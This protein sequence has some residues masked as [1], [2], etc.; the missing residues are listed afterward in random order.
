VGETIVGNLI[1]MAAIWLVAVAVYVILTRRQP[2]YRDIS[3]LKQS[4]LPSVRDR[5][6]VDG[7]LLRP[8]FVPHPNP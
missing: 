4:R 2:Q 5:F 7:A 8:V 3:R 1:L 6:T